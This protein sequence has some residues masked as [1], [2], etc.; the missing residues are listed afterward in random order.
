MSL[1]KYR[2]DKNNPDDIPCLI[3]INKDSMAIPKKSANDF[4]MGPEII[5]F[6]LLENTREIKTRRIV[7]SSR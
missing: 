2:T 1:I 3:F 5:S 4:T 7:R 6:R